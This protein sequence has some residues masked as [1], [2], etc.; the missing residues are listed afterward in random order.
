MLKIACNDAGSEE[1]NIWETNMYVSIRS[2]KPAGSFKVLGQ[3]VSHIILA[4]TC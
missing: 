4:L 2:N 3:T 1:D